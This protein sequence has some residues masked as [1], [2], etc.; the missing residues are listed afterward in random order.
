MDN[1][2]QSDIQ[3]EE[4]WQNQQQEADGMFN[5]ER[6]QEKLSEDNDR[7]AAPADYSDDQKMPA[8]YPTTDTDID[9]GGEYFGGASE[10]TG[11]APEG[12]DSDD[13]VGPVELEHQDPAK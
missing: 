8:D 5:P 13:A 6:D 9:E 10:E 3:R 2:Q 7:P 12:E 4:D 1:T 11:Y